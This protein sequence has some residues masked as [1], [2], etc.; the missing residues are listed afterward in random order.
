VHALHVHDLLHPHCLHAADRLAHI[1]LLSH[2][3]G[4]LV[5]L[6][7]RLDSM[8]NTLINMAITTG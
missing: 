2:M 8:A 6:H 7:T 4:F 3:S 5:I 1:I